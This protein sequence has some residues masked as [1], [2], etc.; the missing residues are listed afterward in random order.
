MKIHF[1]QIKAKVKYLLVSFHFLFFVLVN[2]DTNIRKYYLIF[3]LSCKGRRVRKNKETEHIVKNNHATKVTKIQKN[4]TTKMKWAKHLWKNSG[5]IISGFV[6]TCDE[7]VIGSWIV[8]SGSSCERI[9]KSNRH[10]YLCWFL[11]EW[12]QALCGR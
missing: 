8:E 6:K 2:E 9:K 10:Y 11:A 5:F 7:L 4:E 12:L 3:C 1:Q